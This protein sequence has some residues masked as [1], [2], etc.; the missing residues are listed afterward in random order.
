[1]RSLA[2]PTSWSLTRS[3]TYQI[4]IIVDARLRDRR[5]QR[6][7]SQDE[8]AHQVGTSPVTVRRWEA[9]RAQPQPEHL[10]RLCEV[11]E[12]NAEELGFR[13]Q[14]LSALEIL[15]LDPGD[16][17]D[18]EEIQDAS[19]RLRRSYS[20]TRPADLRRRIDE[21]LRQ[22]RELLTRGRPQWRRELMES[23][24]WLTLLRSTVLADVRE[25]EAAASA[26]HTARGLAQKLGHRD[27]EA[28]TWE[29]EAWMTAS[30]G[31]DY[32]ARELASRGIDVAPVGGHGLVA[33]SLQR[34]RINGSLGEESE[35]LRDILAGERALARIGDVEWPDDHYS[36][37]P[38]KAL[39]YISGTMAALHHPRETIEHAVEVVR[40]NENPAT[41]NYWPT[42]VISAR[43]EW[44]A[45][46]ADLGEEDEAYAIAHRGL[47]DW[48]WFRL[49]PEQRTRRLLRRLRDPRLRFQLRDELEERLRT[50]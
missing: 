20:T 6:L 22:I 43:M 17:P 42:R 16:V 8:L 27:L 11:L 12:T 4:P 44:A 15:G 36:I 38:S 29:T 30:D 48:R 37:D 41:R 33:A 13:V 19:L 10:R 31:R 2:C 39:Y 49:G 40:N 50:T 26:V 5:K 25:Y 23:A 46:L 7:M 18:L 1:M 35:A 32:D 45:A 28:W 14:P 21:R 34:A 3:K 24:A 47:E 9:G